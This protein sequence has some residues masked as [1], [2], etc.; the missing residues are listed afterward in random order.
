MCAK[1]EWLRFVSDLPYTYPTFR[2]LSITY[3]FSKA[4]VKEKRLY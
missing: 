2:Y 1:F 3:V 4:K